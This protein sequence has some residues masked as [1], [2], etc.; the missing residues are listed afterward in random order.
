MLNINQYFASDADYIFFARSAR[1]Q[2]H[3]LSSINFPMHKTKSGTLT[4][5]TVESNYKGTIERILARDNAFS[6]MSSV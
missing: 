6:F 3:L 1:E 2:H 4:A 5:E